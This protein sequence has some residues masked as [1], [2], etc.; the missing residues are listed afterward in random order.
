MLSRLI[1]EEV[2]KKLENSVVNSKSLARR[3]RERKEDMK[4]RVAGPRGFEPRITGSAERDPVVS[5]YVRIMV[6]GFS[7]ALRYLGQMSS[8]L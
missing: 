1:A 6:R 2:A 3:K 5:G 4:E 7:R 8:M